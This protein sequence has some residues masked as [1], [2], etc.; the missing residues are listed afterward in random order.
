VSNQEE[1]PHHARTIWFKDFHQ[2]LLKVRPY[3]SQHFHVGIHHIMFVETSDASLSHWHR[4]WVDSE[5]HPPWKQRFLLLLLLSLQL[6]GTIGFLIA[7]DQKNSNVLQ[8]LL[9]QNGV[10]CDV[11]TK[12]HVASIHT[13]LVIMSFVVEVWEKTYSHLINV[14]FY[15]D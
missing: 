13:I 10:Y 8:F 7:I 15:N 5:P 3:K 11:T 9:Q 2:Y 14:D 1:R 12:D 6:I 4:G